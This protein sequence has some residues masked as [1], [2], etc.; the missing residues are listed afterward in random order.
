MIT[1]LALPEEEEP[2]VTPESSVVLPNESVLQ[3]PP[4]PL[5]P[6]LIV[7][8]R[9]SSI[10]FGSN[11]AEVHSSA[12]GQLF[13]SLNSGYKETKAVISQHTV[14]NMNNSGFGSG[15]ISPSILPSIHSPDRHMHRH[16][17]SLESMEM[18]PTALNES[19]CSERGSEGSVKVNNVL[20][21]V[22]KFE[23]G[24]DSSVEKV[25]ERRESDV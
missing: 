4:I 15:N 17:A 21:L 5:S 2:P 3:H 10:S 16:T 12:D 18:V 8:R 25:S 20:Q 14:S 19:E 7:H 13:V 24:E 22:I 23:R 6:S 1:P 9:A 11:P